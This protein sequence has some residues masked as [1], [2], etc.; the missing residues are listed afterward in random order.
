MVAK[1]CQDARSTVALV[2]DHELV[3]QGIKHVLA[4]DRCMKVVGEA[5]DAPHAISM[6]EQLQPDVVLLD[7][8]LREGSGL[9]V[10]RAC[11]TIAPETKVLI[12]SAHDDQQYVKSLIRMGVR[13]YL[14]KS[15]SGGDLRRAIHDLVEGNLVFPSGVADK[16]LAAFK[17]DDNS[18]DRM[19]AKASL[20]GRESEV[21]GRMSEGLTNREIGT[22]LGIS[23]KTVDAHVRRLLLKLRAKSR[24]Q[25]V[26][27]VMR[28]E[29]PS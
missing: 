7:I 25:A 6:I 19:K 23:M 11:Q 1:T 15:T 2:D 10:A 4:R 26:V 27:S 21:L 18:A 24:T 9:D 20:T 13:G 8:Q 22:D 5:A 3:R 28:G 16:V 12:V 17:Q 14:S 29:A